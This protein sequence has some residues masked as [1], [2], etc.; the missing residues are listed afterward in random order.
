M[1]CGL[2][3]WVLDHPMHYRAAHSGFAQDSPPSV[4]FPSSGYP[5]FKVLQFGVLAEL[6]WNYGESGETQVKFW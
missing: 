6:W 4:G 1:K 5:L 2:L 3:T